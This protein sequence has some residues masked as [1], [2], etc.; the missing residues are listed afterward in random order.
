MHAYSTVSIPRTFQDDSNKEK[1]LK[2][3]WNPDRKIVQSRNSLLRKMSLAAS[4]GSG[5]L[6]VISKK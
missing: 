2:R 4:L 3:T 5:M 6:R 1:T